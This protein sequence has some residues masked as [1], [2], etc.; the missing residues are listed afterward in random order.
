MS[1][2]LRSFSR[3]SFRS[4]SSSSSSTSDPRN[5]N[6]LTEQDN[7]THKVTPKHN[8]F[9]EE[10]RFEEINQNMDDWRTIETSL[11]QGQ[12]YFNCYPY[13]TVSLMDRNIL[14]NP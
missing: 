13:K 11:G 5:L 14:D 10:V 4:S 12:V 8:L 7:Q 6:F 9:D 2:L 3:I 1:R